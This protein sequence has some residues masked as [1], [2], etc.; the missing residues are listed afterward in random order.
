MTNTTAD[1]KSNLPGYVYM[2]YTR[3]CLDAGRQVYKIGR[4]ERTVK[5]R[6]QGYAK[7]TFPLLY[8]KVNNQVRAEDIIKCGF[9]VKFTNIRNFGCE[10][11]E[12]DRI[13]MMEEFQRL[14]NTSDVVVN[15]TVIASEESVASMIEKVKASINNTVVVKVTWIV[16]DESICKDKIVNKMQ[17]DMIVRNEQNPTNNI[18]REKSVGSHHKQKSTDNDIQ[19]E[20]TDKMLT[21]NTCNICHKSFERKEHYIAHMRRKKSCATGDILEHQCTHCSSRFTSLTDYLAHVTEYLIKDDTKNA[22][23]DGKYICKHCG[24]Q[25]TRTNTH[26]IHLSKCIKYADYTKSLIETATLQFTISERD[27]TIKQL[28]K[29]I[30]NAMKSGEVVNDTVRNTINKNNTANTNI[31]ETFKVFAFGKENMN[32]IDKDKL[33]ELLSKGFNAVPDTAKYLHTN[34]MFPQYQNIYVPNLNVTYAIVYTGEQWDAVEKDDVFDSVI[35]K[36]ANYLEKKFAQLVEKKEI[37]SS[38]KQEFERVMDKTNDDEYIKAIKK[39]LNYAFYNNRLAVK[40]VQENMEKA[41]KKA[42]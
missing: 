13:A 7:G 17:L 1:S 16:S 3:D 4:T 12:G 25:T 26:K 2:F 22:Y 39:K 6:L 20:S 42:K 30:K 28:Q 33:L 18:I 8:M 23:I 32:C 36:I 10:Y 37:S 31:P 14:I 11:Y 15:Q 19:K 24:N 9:N 41:N 34:K 35:T 27:H 21:K 40:A 29:Q 5:S 38:T